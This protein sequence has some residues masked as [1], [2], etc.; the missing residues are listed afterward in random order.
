MAETHTQYKPLQRILML[1]RSEK[2]NVYYLY[3]Y[4][5]V[6]GIINLSLPLGIQALVGLVLG[7][8]LSSSWFILALVVTLGVGLAGVTRLAQLSILEN[9]Q[10]R[11]FVNTAFLFGKNLV[12]SAYHEKK[13]NNLK[14][15]STKFFDVITLQKSFTKLLLDFTTSVLQIFFG[16]LLLALYHPL[17]VAI[18]VVLVIVVVFILRA[19]W[20]R[21]IN[22]SRYESD[23]KFET[24]YWLEEIASNRN[25]FNLQLKRNYHIQRTDTNVYNYLVG[26]RSHFK[27]L[28]TQ[29]ML[30]V[31]LKT[32]LVAALLFVG[33]FLLVSEQISLG[34]FVASEILIILLLDSLEKVVMSAEQIYDSAIALE[35]IGKVTDIHDHDDRGVRINMNEPPE[36]SIYDR[37]THSVVFEMKPG[38][39]VCLSGNPGTGRTRILKWFSGLDDTRYEVMVNGVPLSSADFHEYGRH[40][41]L[42]LQGSGIFKGTLVENISLSEHNEERILMPLLKG[43]HLEEF[44]RGEQD[45]LNCFFDGDTKLPNHVT[46]KIAL[47]RALYH[48]PV[49]LLIDDVWSA[50]DRDKLKHI[51][52]FLKSRN[53]TTIVV[54]NLVPVAAAMDRCIEVTRDGFIDHGKIE[55]GRV[56]TAIHNFMW[57]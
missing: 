47:A 17:F 28:F 35:K 1:V 23:Y 49:V 39:M 5:V 27:V 7:G 2:R 11:L 18:G 38:E 53:A 36:L 54:S 32:L 40:V 52:E 57:S 20:Q 15:L 56:P 12:A 44:I 50:F 16:I 21:G 22:S 25:V 43:L 45:G 8:R 3:A 9:V 19:T 34:Q 6:S 46:R 10:R 14:E 33:S 41:G 37:Q 29:L 55:E 42:A 4:A 51:L 24:A 30:A 26:R 48:H 13:Y 31:G